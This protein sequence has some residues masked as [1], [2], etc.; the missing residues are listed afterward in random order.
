MLDFS[1][2][3]SQWA[4][5]YEPSQSQIDLENSRD[6]AANPHNEPYHNKKPRRETAQI[7][8]DLCFHFADQVLL[9]QYGHNY[10]TWLQDHC[11]EDRWTK[12]NHEKRLE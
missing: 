7:I 5:K 3:R 4:L 11:E 8:S 2:L 10:R 9:R 6:Y 12:V 1:Y